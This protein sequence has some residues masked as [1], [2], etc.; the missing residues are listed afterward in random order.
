MAGNLRLDFDNLPLVEAAVR[1][2]FNG[3][4][5]LTYSLV[6]SIAQELQPSF[7]RLQAAEQVEVAPGKSGTQIEFGPGCLPGALYTGHES[8]LSVSLQPDVIVARWAKHPGLQQSPYP[9]YGKLRDSL[10]MAVEAFRKAT[11][12]DYPGI[13]VVNMSYLNF[14][15]VPD[16]ASVVKTYFSDEAQLQAMENAQQVRNLEA[17]WN[18]DD[19]VDVRFAVVQGTAK[20][21]EG[22]TPGYRLT[23][24]AGLRLGEALDAKSGLE[25]VHDVLQE[26]F[27]NLI[28]EQAKREWE[29]QETRD[30]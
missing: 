23:T 12:D 4:L 3:P 19:D 6:N 14:I 7:P 20:L 27:V 24:A 25:S 16:P 10:W 17:G 2:S 11:G 22:P 30:D 15:P 9:R 8:G 13:A 1:A 29:L 18:R 28:S 5:A 26:L 21:P